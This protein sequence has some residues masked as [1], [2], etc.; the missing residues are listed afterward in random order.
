MEA[1]FWSSIKEYHRAWRRQ[2]KVIVRPSI[3]I[4]ATGLCIALI[5]SITMS[6]WGVVD[7][8]T[9]ALAGTLSKMVESEE[10]TPR[11]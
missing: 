7:S 4:I 6:A 9:V 8:I 1:Q 10:K 5:I 3:L 2:M 11:G